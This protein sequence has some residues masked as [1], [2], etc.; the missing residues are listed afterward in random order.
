MRV[1]VWLHI[2]VV[3]GLVG[4]S[5]YFLFKGD[6]EQALLPYPILIIYYLLFARR[7]IAAS[8]SPEDEGHLTN[9]DQK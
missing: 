9:E 1:I 6:F 4:Y 8:S 7:H 5:T 2:L 3:L